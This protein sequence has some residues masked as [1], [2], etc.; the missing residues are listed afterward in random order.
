MHLYLHSV[1]P[2]A[3][4]SQSATKV[5]AVGISR[6]RLHAGQ[7]L[8]I[9]SEAIDTTSI[10]DTLGILHCARGQSGARKY[11]NKSDPFPIPS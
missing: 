9:F 6:D 3:A 5:I 10:P 1:L 2:H 8:C 11:Y 4:T 7:L